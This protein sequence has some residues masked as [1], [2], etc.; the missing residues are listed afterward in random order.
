MAQ[1]DA[2]PRV[3]TEKGV[4]I[5]TYMH[6]F[7]SFWGCLGVLITVENHQPLLHIVAWTAEQRQ[8][9]DGRGE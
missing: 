6:R 3:G 5:P 8:R 2:K 9:A 7:R 1:V 4:R